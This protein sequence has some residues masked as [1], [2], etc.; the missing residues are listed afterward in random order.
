MN[1][2]I[3]EWIGPFSVDFTNESKNLVYVRDVKVCNARPLNVAQVKPYYSPE[4][5]AHA[6]VESLRDCFR[7]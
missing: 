7:D 5:I 6:F 1:N 2:R 4:D 3:G